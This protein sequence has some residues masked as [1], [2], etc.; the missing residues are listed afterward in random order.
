MTAASLLAELPR[1][2]A[3]ITLS[4]DGAHLL[5]DAPEGFLTDRVCNALA[6][7]KPALIA[8]LTADRG[9]GLSWS[10]AS[11]AFAPGILAGLQR[12]GASGNLQAHFA[13]AHGLPVPEEATENSEAAPL[14]VPVGT[15]HTD[16]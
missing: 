1:R 14:A 11:A 16:V 8:L 12:E 3:A 13:H 4:D 2:D 15:G 7:H 5:V 6:R 9:Q 10:E